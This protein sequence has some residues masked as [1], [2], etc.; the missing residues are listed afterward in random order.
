MPRASD[1]D[2]GAPFAPKSSTAT[3][4]RL[5]AAPTVVRCQPKPSKISEVVEEENK[6]R[7][8]RMVWLWRLAGGAQISKPSTSRR[9]LTRLLAFCFRHIRR[10]T[11][12]FSSAG[13]SY[14]T[15]HCN[16]SAIRSLRQ[17]ALCTRTLS[18]RSATRTAAMR[19]PASFMRAAA[20]VAGTSAVRAFSLSAA[21]RG[22][23][24][25]TVFTL[26]Y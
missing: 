19:V 13:F 10:F 4:G 26:C 14:S 5:K 21:R 6:R 15:Y 20:P 1:A 7:P 22:E 8:S 16:M 23:G 17:L 9:V 11:P 12:L 2:D 25:C 3:P 24:P 18:A